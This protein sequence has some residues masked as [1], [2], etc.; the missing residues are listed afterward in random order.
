MLLPMSNDRSQPSRRRPPL[1]APPGPILVV[2]P[3]DRCDPDLAIAAARAGEVGI[4]D[5]GLAVP[6]PARVAALERLARHAGEAPAWGVRWDTL[7]RA[8]RALDDLTRLPRRPWPWLVVAGLAPEVSTAALRRAIKQARGLAR[9]V[10]VETLDPEAALAAAAQDCDG[11]V[12]K[13]NEA[14]GRVGT[15]SSLMLLQRLHGAIERPFWIQGAWGPD[16]A[17]AALLVGAGIVL[18][19]ELWLARE[20]SLAPDDRQ[21]LAD[22]DGTETVCIGHGRTRARVF[23]P[24][25]RASLTRLEREVED[26]APW[27]EALHRLWLAEE[28]EPRAAPRALGQ[29]IGV[30]ARLARRYHT[31]GAILRAFRAT[32]ADR[33]TLARDQR[34]LGPDAPL[35]RAL[36]LRYPLFQGPM[37]RVSDVPEFCAAVAS[38]GALPFLALALMRGPEV[39][40]LLEA[41]R[42]R[43]GDR[44]WGVGILGF[45]PPELR[46]EQLTEVAAVAPRAAIIAGGRPAQA[47]GL[48]ER[49]IATWLH[50]PSPALL[51]EFVREGTRRFIFEGSE[52][53]GH[54]GPRSSLTLWQ[55]AVDTLLDAGLADPET[56]QVLFAGG[57][58]DALSAAIVQAVAAPLV[59][60]GMQI[61]ALMGTAYLF[62][63]EAVACGAIVPGFQQQALEC[64]QTVLLDSGGGHATRCAHT[65]FAGEF[66]ARKRLL[67]RQGVPAEELR[68]DLEML[69]VGRLRVASKGLARAAAPAETAVSP[70]DA[71]ETLLARGAELLRGSLVEVDQDAQLREGMYMIGEVATLRRRS[72]PMAEL[73]EDVCRGGVETLAQLAERAPEPRGAAAPRTG[74]PIAIVGMACRF[75]GAGDLRAF[76]GNL[77]TGIDAVREVP[78]ERWSSELYYSPERLAPDRLYSKWGA[79]LEPCRFDPVSHGIPP[80]SVASIEPIQL[81]ALDVAR[82]ALEDAG[83]GAGRDFPRQ[84]TAVIFA[85]GGVADVG[86][87]YAMRTML[88]QYLAR[89]EGL[90]P[91]TRER[92]VD[93]VRATTPPWTEDSFPG[94]LLNV[95]SGRVANRLDLGGPNYIVD[96]ACAASLA[97][98]STAVEQLRAGRCDMALVGGADGTNNAFTFMSF[99]KTHALTPGGVAR[100]FDERADGIVLGEGVA[101][102]VLKRLAD[103]ERDGDRVWAVI[104]GL[105]NSSDGR[106]RSLTAP[107]AAAQTR[108][109]ERA[110]A[111]AGVDPASVTLLEAHAT[112]TA[113]GDRA[114]IE[115][116]R[117]VFARDERGAYCAIGSV[118]SMIGHTKTVAGL[119]GMIKATLALA[120]RQLP[121]TLHVEVPNRSAGL[122]RGP[123]YV[124]TK[125]RPWLAGADAPRRAGVSAFGFGGTNFH[126]VLEE[127]RGEYRAD[128]V[129][130]LSPRPVELFCWQ[131]PDREALAAEV[132]RLAAALATAPGIALPS[133]AAA[134]LADE[135]AH[136]ARP[137]GVRLAVAAESVGDLTA[138]L[139]RA[140]AALGAGHC[141]DD[142]AGLW[143][144]DAEPMSPASVCFLFP[145][146]G[147]QR[148]DMLRDL[149]RGERDGNGLAE[150]T[151]RLLADLL[152]RSLSSYIWPT[153]VF[154]RAEARR[155]Q[156]ELDDTRIAQPALG[157]VNLLATETLGRF[158]LRPAAVAGHSYG[159]YVALTVA[160]F[161]SHADM[162]RLSALRGRA[163]HEAG[164]DQPGG[165]AAVAASE[166]ETRAALEALSI[167]AT[168]ANINGPRQIV[169]AG[170][171]GAIDEAIKRLPERGLAVRRVAVTAA[172]HSP[173]VEGPSRALAVLLGQIEM[174][175]PGIPVYSNVTG[176]PYPA[177]LE[178]IRQLLSIHLARP[179]RFTDQVLAMHRD[180]HRVFIEAGPGRV[181]TGLVRRILEGL[182][183]TALALESTGRAGHA[184]LAWLL[185]QAFALGL[186]VNLDP[187]FEGRGLE[188]TPL[189]ECLERE[190]RKAA[191]RPTDWIVGPQGSRPAQAPPARP[192]PAARVSAAP[193]EARPA[194]AGSPAAAGDSPLAR[195]F[196][197]SMQGWL[198]LQREQQRLTERFLDLQERIVAEMTG[199]APAS[200]P[201]RATGAPA[202]SLPIAPAPVVAAAR[203]LPALPPP[204]PD[205]APAEPAEETP[206]APAFESGEPPAAPPGV[207]EFQA[208]LLAE[209]SRRTGYPEDMLDLDVHLEAGLGIDSIKTME[210]F[211]ALKRHHHA[212]IAA[213]GQD[214]EEYLTELMQL[215][216]LRDIV[217]HYA[218][219][220]AAG[221]AAPPAGDAAPST[222]PAGDAQP[223][224]APAAVERLV[225]RPVR[226]ALPDAE[227]FG[228]LPTFPAD[229]SLLVVGDVPELVTGL[230]AALARHGHRVVQLAPGAKSKTLGPGRFEADLGDPA[231]L[232]RLAREI[233][234]SG[235]V[236]VGALVNL[237]PLGERARQIGL[238]GHD[239]PLVLVQWMTHVAQA[240]EE[241]I[242][243]ARPDGAGW[244]IN[245]TTLG[246]RFGLGHTKALPVAQA[247][248]LGIFKSL[249]REWRGVRVKNIDLDPQAEPAILL[250][251]LLQ[252]LA[253]DDPAVEVGLDGEGRWKL[254]L[255]SEAAA[256]GEAAARRLPL[257][258]ESLVLATGGADGITA[259]VVKRLAGRTGTRLALV[260]R[261]PLAP[262]EAEPEELRRIEDPADLRRALIERR[263]AAGPAVPAEIERELRQLLKAR[264]VRATVEACR[265]A[266]SVTEYH[267]LDVRDLGA[268]GA[269]IDEL[270]A[271]HGRIDGVLHGAGVLED[272]FLRDKTAASVARVFE[273]KVNGAIALARGLRPET[274][275]FL[276]FFSSLSGRFGNAGQ[277]DYS[278]ANE[279]LNKLAVHLDHQWPARVFSIAWGPWNTGMISDGLRTAYAERGIGLI[280]IEAGVDALLDELASSETHAPEVALTCT[281]QRITELVESAS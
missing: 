36:G 251:G 53:G 74:E 65:P 276:V 45:V 50:V 235:G 95:L 47:R 140:L 142:A 220:L 100:P 87:A 138:K 44:P 141:L 55:D 54:V 4:L 240:F 212:V 202:G 154:D 64:G 253:D 153:P 265:Q 63:H 39:R 37:T 84:R 109:L 216:T 233:R 135:S 166:E 239:T 259:E 104:R 131:R 81:L 198:E 75:P 127:H 252:E 197:E 93:G 184:G 143:L 229:R 209:V 178:S 21:R 165:M 31:T 48:E 98:V 189:A 204:D 263:R 163:V 83:Y 268:F 77:L 61:G 123:F 225:L 194:V 266:G 158:G 196:Q 62:T 59:A 280:G 213:P 272:R 27:P 188:P 113:V 208:C 173:A 242:R 9:G 224:P 247:G 172:F 28:C 3:P 79:F 136:R 161:S 110:Y 210:I 246:G 18:G 236:P 219:R 226:T 244:L 201:V 245:V 258:P 30:A 73:H 200:R 269:L 237:L 129:P 97:A 22:L 124:N 238:N 156:A 122:D 125:T 228:R 116:S 76:C 52:C 221:G 102:V 250:V 107:H 25:G 105:G 69:N 256:A 137:G 167:E 14:G 42:E 249:G 145:G 40:R 281:P 191:G 181:L 33:P 38:N 20:S 179:V 80:A 24:G 66:A 34:S 23:V 115:A 11:V 12:L 13:A 149:V 180:G 150:S 190:R 278:A 193:D 26:G 273:T 60:R 117:E 248:S 174:R 199:G 35:A 108:A 29:G 162:L 72:V 176:Q 214:E 119:A 160:G 10:L 118:K 103:A 231:A 261:T 203:P 175:P 90:D 262:A 41:T 146:Q 274:L 182:P 155:Q 5:L 46:R 71:R 151:D 88:P 89:V 114:E 2:T 51:G 82:A 126:V 139:E 257:G 232:A 279:Y 243:A 186:P 7:G 205:F 206:P 43:L 19:E 148:I 260:G 185:G 192:V 70:A 170:S 121:P 227:S 128:A 8:D 195:Q 171:V 112:G 152:P 101:A 15:L 271:R 183:H 270:Y 85:S 211:G 67:V 275:R 264:R 241:D 187:W 86:I 99:A 78:P 215:K 207:A 56:V 277:T 32:A 130:D 267:A 91:A 144:S 254:E 147:S 230:A 217:N 164:R 106:N 133:L 157:L 234:E 57:I 134:V 1:G 177:D 16:A 159:E 120:H 223:Q 222:P 218:K 132:S 6:D 111:D 96:A 17:A 68:F 168:I 169:I 58:H 49:G 94:I 92:I 255:V